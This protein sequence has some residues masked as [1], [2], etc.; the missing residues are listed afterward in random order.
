VSAYCLKTD[1]WQDFQQFRKEAEEY[2]AAGNARSKNRCLR[3]G[4]LCLYAHTEGVISDVILKMGLD[5]KL[6]R[7]AFL[8]QCEAIETYLKDS[9]KTPPSFRD[10][11]K[12]IR[13]TIAHPGED[14]DHGL[15]FSELTLAALD[16]FEKGISG[17][18]DFVCSSTGVGRFSDT[19]KPVED[20]TAALGGGGGVQEV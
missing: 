7:G 5:E 11:G 1:L 19:K 15:P 9:G 18:L 3:A 16:D 12:A 13:N 2:A 20:F 17:W 14:K 10:F 6:L 4:L 8:K